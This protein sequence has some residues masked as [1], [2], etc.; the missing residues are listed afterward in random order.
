ML[1]TAP[2]RTARTITREFCIMILVKACLFGPAHS[3]RPTRTSVPRVT[4]LLLMKS[5]CGVKVCSADASQTGRT[6]HSEKLFHKKKCLTQLEI[7][8]VNSGCGKP[9]SFHIFFHCSGPSEEDFFFFLYFFFLLFFS[10]KRH[11]SEPNILTDK[12]SPTSVIDC[13]L[14]QLQI[15]LPTCAIEHLQ[16]MTLKN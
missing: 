11:F 3:I 12:H 9:S 15:R 2:Q 10:E 1:R 14:T 4:C 7:P 16:S 8:R 6:G 5:R 13:S